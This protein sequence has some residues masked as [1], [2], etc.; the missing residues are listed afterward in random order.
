MLLNKK[1]EADIKEKESKEMLVNAEKI[2]EESQ[3]K[4]D[5]LNRENSKLRNEL[6]AARQ[7]SKRLATKLE[8]ADNRLTSRVMP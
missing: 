4:V 3:Q 5:Q 8:T 2:R 7:R 6:N 1:K